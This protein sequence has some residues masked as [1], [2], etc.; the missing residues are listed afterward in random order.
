MLLIF[1]R[2]TLAYHSCQWV[3]TATVV[4]WLVRYILPKLFTLITEMIVN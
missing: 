4:D 1:F 3:K 2:F